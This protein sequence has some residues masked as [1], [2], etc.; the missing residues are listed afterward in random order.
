MTDDSTGDWGTAASQS[1]ARFDIVAQFAKIERNCRLHGA[2]RDIRFDA[3][4]HRSE[5]QNGLIGK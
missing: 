1:S 4:A 2:A 3:L 5:F